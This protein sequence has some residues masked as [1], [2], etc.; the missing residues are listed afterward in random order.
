MEEKKNTKLYLFSTQRCI[1]PESGKRTL[2]LCVFPIGFNIRFFSHSSEHFVSLLLFCVMSFQS[3][4]RN[5]RIQEYVQYLDV[6]CCYSVVYSKIAKWNCIAHRLTKLIIFSWESPGWIV[7]DSS[8]ISFATLFLLQFLPF[9]IELFLVCCFF[10]TLLFFRWKVA[11]HKLDEVNRTTS[12][13]T[14]D[15]NKLYT[16]Q[17]ERKGVRID[18]KFI[19]FSH[20]ICVFS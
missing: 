9:E 4:V 16:N 1:H 15:R 5:C 18:N 3:H 10:L 20:Y 2:S 13:T 6:G 7:D 14:E 19:Y 17:F 8:S 12:A 11:E